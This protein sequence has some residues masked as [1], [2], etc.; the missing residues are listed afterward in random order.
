MTK[1]AIVLPLRSLSVLDA[2]LLGGEQAPAA[3][4]RADEQLD[5]EALFERLQPV[6][7]Q[8]RAGVGLVGGERLDGASGR[9]SAEG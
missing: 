3:A 2:R 5:V 6:A 7:D 8:A 9:S 1:V 4:M